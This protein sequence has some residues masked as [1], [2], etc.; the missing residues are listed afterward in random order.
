MDSAQSGYQEAVYANMSYIK[1]YSLLSG[2]ETSLVAIEDLGEELLFH[3]TTP[4]TGADN[5]SSP[6]ELYNENN[7]N[8]EIMRQRAFTL[9]FTSQSCFHIRFGV[10]VPGFEDTVDWEAENIE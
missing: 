1:D 8:A 5:P 4:G 6:S 7:T 3:S 2:E 9:H 10:L